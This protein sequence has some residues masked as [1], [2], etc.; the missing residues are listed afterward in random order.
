MVFP[1][2]YEIRV[3][4][5]LPPSLRTAFVPL[6]SSV[7]AGGAVTVLNGLIGDQAELTGILHTLDS[8]GLILLEVAPDRAVTLEG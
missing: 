4:G 7:E 8:L 6:S 5:T 1:Q 2:R 3:K